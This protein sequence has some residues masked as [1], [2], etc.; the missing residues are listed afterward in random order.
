MSPGAVIWFTGLPA[1]GKSTLAG[2]VRDAL[3]ATGCRAL[4]LDGDEVRRTLVPRHGYTEAERDDFYASLAGLAALLARQ[5]FLVLVAAT[6]QRARWRELARALAPRFV[7]VF[8]AASPSECAKRDPKGLYAAA[9][10]G[11]LTGLPGADAAYEA[12]VLPDVISEGGLDPRAV[13][14]VLAAIDV[15]PAPAERRGSA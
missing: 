15:K 4:L 5:G 11:D 9:R 2:R 12:P 1:S 13:G 8:V 3:A 7:E 6:A 10:A 14:R